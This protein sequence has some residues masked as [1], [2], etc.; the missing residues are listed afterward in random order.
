MKIRILIL[1]LM[2]LAFVGCQSFRS[3]APAGEN[4]ATVI[5][6]TGYTLEVQ[7][8]GDYVATLGRGETYHLQARQDAEGGSHPV[9]LVV[10]AYED[11][12]DYVGTAN[13]IFRPRSF[14]VWEVTSSILNRPEG[15]V[16]AE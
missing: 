14:A 1:S 8:Q 2:A 10:L 15:S 6:Q 16:G 5:N 4:I 3:A 12:G 9:T 11:Q 7:R 13:R